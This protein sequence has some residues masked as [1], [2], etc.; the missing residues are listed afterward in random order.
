M[1]RVAKAKETEQERHVSPALTVE[2]EEDEL[3]S[4]AVGLAKERLLDKTASNDLV[5]TIIQFGTTKARLEKEK[6]RKETDLLVAKAQAIEEAKA[7]EVMFQDAIA[8]MK[9]YGY[10]SED[11]EEYDDDEEDV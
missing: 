9:S 6:L 10:R 7:V 3:I 1:P 4:L 11:S 8:A 2:E 5:R